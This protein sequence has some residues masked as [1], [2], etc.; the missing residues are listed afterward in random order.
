MSA[1]YYIR[2]IC[3]AWHPNLRQPWGPPP[4]C[5]FDLGH[6]GMHYAIHVADAGRQAVAWWDQPATHAATDEGA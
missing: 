2:I 6:T 4:S 3:G 5:N 1:R